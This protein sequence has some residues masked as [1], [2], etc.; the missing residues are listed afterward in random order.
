MPT[1]HIEHLIT[2]FDIWKAAFDRVAPIRARSGVLA[3]RVQR[4]VGEPNFVVVDLDFGTTSEAESFLA[5]LQTNI[6]STK[7]NS[8]A[9]DGTPVTRILEPAERQ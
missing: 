4:P 9:L 5:F 1:L 3:H 7:E 2:D 8:P 6:W